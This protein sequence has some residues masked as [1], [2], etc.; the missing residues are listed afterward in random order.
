MITHS[1]DIRKLSVVSSFEYDITN[2]LYDL[3]NYVFSFY[4]LD[5]SYI[6]WTRILEPRE[7]LLCIKFKSNT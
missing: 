7:I 4:T 5:L 2:K 6:R 3:N 1:T